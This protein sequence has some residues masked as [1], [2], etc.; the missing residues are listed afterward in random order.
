[1]GPE[2]PYGTLARVAKVLGKGSI[3]HAGLTP[4]FDTC[5][6][7]VPSLPGSQYEK[8]SYNAAGCAS[9]REITTSDECIFALVSLGLKETTGAKLWQGSYTTIPRFCSVREAHI[10]GASYASGHFNSAA[11]GKG[12]DDLA[13]I[14]KKAAVSI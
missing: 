8:L 9:G 6:Q 1:L 13:P 5:A 3:S 4:G 7:A 11:S 2:H 10:L 14:C 12:R